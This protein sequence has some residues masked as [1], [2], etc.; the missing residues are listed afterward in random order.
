MN[1]EL[2]KDFEID[3]KTSR[4]IGYRLEGMVN[5]NSKEQICPIHVSLLIVKDSV[6]KKNHSTFGEYHENTNSIPVKVIDTKMDL[7]KFF[8][9]YLG[10]VGGDIVMEGLQEKHFYEVNYQD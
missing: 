1:D 6:W 2:L 8:N 5:E 10:S 4:L 7:N 3:E 9:K